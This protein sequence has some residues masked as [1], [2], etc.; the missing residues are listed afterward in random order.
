MGIEIPILNISSKEGEAVLRGLEV[1][2]SSRSDEVESAVKE[3]LDSIRDN[4]DS[5]LF[6]C[7]E[8][9]DNRS[10]NSGNVKLS[11]EYIKSQAGK[12]DKLLAQSIIEAAKRI[13]VYH[14]KQMRD[15]SFT[16]ETQEGTLS[17]LQLPLK[18]VALYVPG[19]YT[20]YPSTVLMNGIPAKVAGVEE[21]VAVTPCRDGQLHPAIA[22]AFDLLGI[23]EVYQIGGAQAI[24]ALAYGTDSIKSVDKIVGPGN[25]YVATAKKIVYGAVDID[26]VAGPSEVAILADETAN[27]SWIALDLLSQAE[28]GSGDESAVL[29]TESVAIAKKVVDAL[30]LEIEKSPVKEIFEKLSKN[31]ITVFVSNNREESYSFINRLGPEHLEIITKEPR[32]DLSH[33]FNA[34]AIFLGQFTPVALGDY[35]IGTN[36][37]LPTAAASRYASP[38]GVD[39]FLKRVSVAEVTADGIKGCVDHLS[40]FARSEGFVH[41]AMSVERRVEDIG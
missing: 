21:I 20:V 22:F 10:L 15:G 38:L 2:R 11:K 29:V 17:Q 9:F 25:S 30:Y 12:I 34:A 37:V 7:A 4:G 31:A 27:P 41:H 19:G 36:H 1:Q 39:S 18:R 26:S 24:G 28:H 32:E 35:F 16:I 40:R 8:K 33:I 5:A 14:K 13:E 23:Y 3:V 6:T